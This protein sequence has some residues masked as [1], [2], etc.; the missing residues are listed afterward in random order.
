MMI[1]KRKYPSYGLE[2]WTPQRPAGCD[3]EL[4]RGGGGDVRTRA[5][6]Q[7]RPTDR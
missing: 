2:S 4:E 3:C 5:G 7:S 1:E 6:C